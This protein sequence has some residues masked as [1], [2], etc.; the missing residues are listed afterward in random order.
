MGKMSKFF[1]FLCC[2]FLSTSWGAEAPSY[3]SAFKDL[4]PY[5]SLRTLSSEAERELVMEAYQTFAKTLKPY[6]EFNRDASDQ[7]LSEWGEFGEILLNRVKRNPNALWTVE[8]QR[9][10][11]YFTAELEVFR[12]EKKTSYCWFVLFYDRLAELTRQ[13]CGYDN[14]VNSTVGISFYRRAIMKGDTILS[15]RAMK[16]ANE[17]IGNSY[18]RLI[19]STLGLTKYFP[20]VVMLP[21]FW[22]LTDWDIA[23]KRIT[24]QNNLFLV[25]VTE[26]NSVFDGVTGDPSIYLAHEMSHVAYLQAEQRQISIAFK[27]LA[28]IRNMMLPENL[29]FYHQKIQHRNQFYFDFYERVLRL[30]NDRNVPI[31]EEKRLLEFFMFFSSHEDMLSIHERLKCMKEMQLS[32]EFLRHSKYYAPLLPLSMQNLDGWAMSTRI[33]EMKDKFYSFVKEEV[34]EGVY[35]DFL[36][37]IDSDEPLS[38]RLSVPVGS[39]VTELLGSIYP[40]YCPEKKKKP[41]QVLEI[42]AREELFIRGKNFWQPTSFVTILFGDSPEDVHFFACPLTEDDLEDCLKLQ[43]ELGEWSSPRRIK[44]RDRIPLQSPYRFRG[45]VVQSRYPSF[46]SARIVS[47]WMG[48][49]FM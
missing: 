4:K 28:Q 10:L 30:I 21:Y 18:T 38:R 12:K 22:P 40:Y 16:Q 33:E 29:M 9:K 34:D 48:Q 3:Q 37:E 41:D 47:S 32:V 46:G 6:F 23:L 24:N 8:N 26:I 42:I 36:K 17:M 20:H 31:P 49:R 15:H 19:Y 7:S 45:P 27:N 35:S 1:I 43:K 44:Y 11:S 25:E 5:L 39:P 14:I 13:V 2:V